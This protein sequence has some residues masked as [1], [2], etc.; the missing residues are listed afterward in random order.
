[1]TLGLIR[2]CEAFSGK[3]V[4]SFAKLTHLTQH[5]I[6]PLRRSSSVFVLVAVLNV[7]LDTGRLR[8]YVSIEI[9]LE[10]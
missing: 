7:P 5:T 4:L 10:E 9:T 3:T 2:R 6:L 8:Q 1:M